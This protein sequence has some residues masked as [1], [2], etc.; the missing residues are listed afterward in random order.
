MP[1]IR[2]RL[3]NDEATILGLP[4][5]KPEQGRNTF[6]YYITK[7]QSDIINELR[8]VNPERAFIETQKK[9]DKN[10]EVVSTIEKLQATPIDIPPN[11]EI[12]KISTSKTT[13][14]Q[15]IQYAPKKGEEI[16]LEDVN[17]EDLIQKYTKRI[18]V[19]PKHIDSG[20][21]IFDRAVITDVHIGME[22]NENGYSLYG[23]KWD[24]DEVMD[25]ADTV[26]SHIVSNK[27]SNVLIF[28]D[29][30][31]FMDG[32]DGETARKGH[33]LPQN[34]DNEKAFDVG[35]EFRMRI[36]DGLASE[37]ESIIFNFIVNDNHASSYGYITNAAFKGIAELKY[38]HVKAYIHRKFISHYVF[39]NKCFIISHGKDDKHLKFGFKPQLDSKQIEKIENYIKEHRL[40]DYE[41]EFSK[42]DSHQ[43][44]FDESSSDSFYYYNYGAL[45]P[46]SDWVQSNYKKG[47]SF[48][49]FFNFKEKGEKIHNPYRFE[50]NTNR[51]E[52]TLNLTQ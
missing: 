15:W 3:S 17:F 42:G 7:E 33:K 31:D 4:L 14:Q 12:I 16:S 36:L 45:S 40:Y 37:Y 27:K 19:S 28:D 32:W 18:N 8:G 39:Q 49:E 43:K 9:L 29:L 26:V 38:P 35:V 44:L 52:Q 1:K 22:T 13:G 30:G 23:G 6:L 48:F 50:W 2:R 41:I 20:N 10:G 5:A 51:E 25:R 24:R 21:F 34:M 11:F 47:K 46:S